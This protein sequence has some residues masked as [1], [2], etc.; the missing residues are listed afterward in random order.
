MLF[1]SYG[2]L[3]YTVCYQ[4]VHLSAGE[5]KSAHHILQTRTTQ[6]WILAD[7]HTL[8]WTD[9][10]IYWRKNHFDLTWRD[11]IWIS[12]EWC[13]MI[14]GCMHARLAQRHIRT[15]V[16][17]SLFKKRN[18]FS[19]L[20]QLLLTVWTLAVSQSGSAFSSI[21]KFMFMQE[22]MC[23]SHVSDGPQMWTLQRTNHSL[24]IILSKAISP[25]K[26]SCREIRESGQALVWGR[27]G[28]F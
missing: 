13:V 16:R 8:T 7:A 11:I 24:G 19:H 18:E 28:M 1:Y 17:T 14:E 22:I 27:G 15:S 2:L 23:C 3:H 12:S 20:D 5:I 26:E 6:L 21:T 9:I 4:S 25:T 10:V